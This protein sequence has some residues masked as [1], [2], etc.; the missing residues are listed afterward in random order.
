MK[1]KLTKRKRSKML[2][3]FSYPGPCSSYNIRTTL[4]FV[5]TLQN[6]RFKIV[7]KFYTENQFDEKHRIVFQ[8]LQ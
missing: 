2:F 4:Y 3:L 8:L 1:I 7:F 6:E 5:F